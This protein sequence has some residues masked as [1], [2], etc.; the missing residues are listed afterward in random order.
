MAAWR[1]EESMSEQFEAGLKQA[2]AAVNMLKD[3]IGRV[4]VGQSDVVNQVMWGLAAGG[5]V[6]LEGAPGLGKTLLVRT[7]SQCLDL[8]FSRIQFTPD[9]MPSDVTGTNVL[10]MDPSQ[11]AAGA[12]FSV[13][14]GPIFGQIV[15]ADEINRATPKTQSA[16]LE[17]MAE[18]AVT[19]GGTRHAL[20]EPFFVLATENPIEMEGTY[21]LPEAQ[22]DRFLLKVIVPNPSE[23]E[24]VEVLARTTGHEQG[25]PPRVLG[26]DGVLRLRSMCRDVVVAEPVARYAARLVRASDPTSPEAPDLVKRSLRYGAGVRGA[27][28]LVLA[29]KAVALC[30]G[31]ANVSFADVA[32]VAKPALRHRIIRSFEGEADGVSTDTVID[33][34]LAS[35]EARPASVDAE[36]TRQA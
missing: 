36:R 9:L 24:L 12:M 11:R 32:G 30:E 18:H 29:A 31:R 27:Q 8:R 4:V 6:L 19:I 13:Q 22:L 3:A 10:V 14:K 23:N 33:A 2:A 21:P 17:A 34:L 7:L 20:E 28:S 16:L 25:A 15:L 5:H 1:R 26:R 35:V